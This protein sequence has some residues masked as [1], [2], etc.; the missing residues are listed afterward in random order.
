MK[1][2][3]AIIYFI[4][5]STTYS[6]SLY[7][8]DSTN[9]KK[10]P[11]NPLVLCQEIFLNGEKVQLDTNTNIPLKFTECVNIKGAETRVYHT[12]TVV[13]API[14]LTSYTNQKIS[15]PTCPPLYPVLSNSIK[16][17]QRTYVGTLYYSLTIK[18]CKAAFKA[19]TTRRWVPLSECPLSKP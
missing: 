11:R 2:I 3:T 9:I 12:S 10:N 13:G 7:A 14:G 6:L 4:V 1:K 19:S 5:L 8:A 15:N 17:E 16:L 18:C